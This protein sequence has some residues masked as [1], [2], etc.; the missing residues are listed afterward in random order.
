MLLTAFG[1][2][3]NAEQPAH[4]GRPW[5]FRKRLYGDKIPEL[6][7]GHDNFGHIV[8]QDP[9]GKRRQ[10][11]LLTIRKHRIGY[12][13][14]HETIWVVGAFFCVRYQQSDARTTR[15]PGHHYGAAEGNPTTVVRHSILS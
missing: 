4:E 11:N 9:A 1:H 10:A 12:R 2:V 5:P 7:L 6:P 3:R 14:F 15:Q 13:L 8:I